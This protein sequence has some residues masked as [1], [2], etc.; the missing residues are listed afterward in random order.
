MSCI[1]GEINQ[2][3]FRI[4]LEWQKIF[5][6]FRL[7]QNESRARE[8]LPYT[9]NR[10]SPKIIEF[11]LISKSFLKNDKVDTGLDCESLELDDDI[12]LFEE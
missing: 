4:Y 1:G 11:S 5:S 3:H 9:R 2:Q 7:R 6:V 10:L 12:E 8:M